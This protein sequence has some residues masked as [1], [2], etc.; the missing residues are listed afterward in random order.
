[1]SKKAIII[2]A[3]IIAVAV[4]GAVLLYQ[5]MLPKL[6]VRAIT[7]ENPPSAILPAKVQN[8]V[9]IIKDNVNERMDQIAIVLDTSELEFDDVLDLVDKVDA[10][11]VIMTIEE[12]QRT[13]IVD[14]EQVFDIAVKN[15]NFHGFDVEQF[16]AAFIKHARVKRILGILRRIKEEDLLNAIS[17]PVARRTAKMLLQDKREEIESNMST[18]LN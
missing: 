7:S 6:I 12:L 10:D 15:I 4:I 11:E 2:S 1:M 14:S 18:Q 9:Q 8:K 16:R 5:Y 17:V 3:S 13:E